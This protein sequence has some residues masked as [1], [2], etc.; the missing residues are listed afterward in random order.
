MHVRLNPLYRVTRFIIPDTN[1]SGSE[2]VSP[3]DLTDIQ[4]EEVAER[5]RYTSRDARRI[6]TGVKFIAEKSV[7]RRPES[8]NSVAV[9]L[10]RERRAVGNLAGVLSRP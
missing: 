4:S 9:S 3:L 1:G 10:P 7:H 6:S 2:G 5:A 8:C